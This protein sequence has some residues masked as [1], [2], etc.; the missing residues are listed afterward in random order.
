MSI[1]AIHQEISTWDT[2]KLRELE[3]LAP[4]GWRFLARRG[5]SKFMAI[6]QSAILGAVVCWGLL[7]TPRSNAAITFATDQPLSFALGDTM[8]SQGLIRPTY[9]TNNDTGEVFR[10]N[11]GP[12]GANNSFFS[13]HWI[14]YLQS[15][16]GTSNIST[17]V[18]LGVDRNSPDQTTRLLN[19]TV[20]A[21]LDLVVG[22]HENSL[23]GP[24][25]VMPAFTSAAL[26]RHQTVRFV[27]YGPSQ[28]WGSSTTSDNGHSQVVNMRVFSTARPTDIGLVNDAGVQ[29]DGGLINSNSTTIGYVFDQPT[30][31]WQMAAVIQTGTNIDP[32]NPIVLNGAVDLYASGAS[33]RI[34]AAIPE[35]GTPTLLLTTVGLATLAR[36]RRR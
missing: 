4:R 24:A 29:P 17:S 11:A 16:W 8:A 9:F 3:A 15:L 12:A 6:I 34:L 22:Q 28:V 31:V 32:S 5:E 27:G 14:T 10:G 21:D 20:F 2:R 13:Y 26:T 36:K 33:Q 1:E 35:P 18:G 7:A 19:L 30:Q 23:T 25:A